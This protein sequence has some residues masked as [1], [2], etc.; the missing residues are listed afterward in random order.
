MQGTLEGG[1]LVQGA[2]SFTPL[3]FSQ[4]LMGICCSNFRII[5]F[6]PFSFHQLPVGI[7][8]LEVISFAHSFTDGLLVFCG[9]K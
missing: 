6:L 4:Q 9:L 8:W 7:P 2:G 5:L 3:S 1:T